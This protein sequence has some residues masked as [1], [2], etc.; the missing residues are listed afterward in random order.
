MTKLINT[1]ETERMGKYFSTIIFCF[2]IN[3]DYLIDLLID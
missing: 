1:K 3:N 2:Q